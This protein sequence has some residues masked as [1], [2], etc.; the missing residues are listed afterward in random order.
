MSINTNILDLHSYFEDLAKKHERILHSSEKKHF[1]KGGLEEFFA[2]LRNKVKF[3]A[4]V[5]DGFELRYDGKD[6]DIQKEREF[7]FTICQQFETAGNVEQRTQAVSD[8]EKIGEEFIKKIIYDLDESSCGFLFSCASG[9]LME[10]TNE[11]YVG[12]EFTCL[13]TSKF[14]TKLDQTIWEN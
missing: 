8:C 7:S 4:V 5:F 12:I 14:N 1:F 10:N 2:G 6:D 13:L 11:K 3:P 9:I